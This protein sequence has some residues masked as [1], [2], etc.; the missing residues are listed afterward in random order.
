M[1]LPNF[2]NLDLYYSDVSQFGEYQYSTLEEIVNNFMYEQ[3]DDSY[4]SQVDRG[5]VAR[6]LQFQFHPCVLC[7]RAVGTGPSWGSI[8]VQ[9]VDDVAVVV[10]GD[11]HVHPAKFQ[12]FCRE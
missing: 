9:A 4:V 12:T 11:R 5:R 2:T 7:W 8:G 6:H 3:D 10:A 1:A